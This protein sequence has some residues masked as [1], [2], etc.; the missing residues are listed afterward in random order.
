MSESVRTE[1]L[2]PGP[3]EGLAGLLD[4]DPP[5]ETLPPL[6]HWVYLLDR[7]AQRDLGPDGHPVHGI[8][9]PPAPGLLRMFAGGRIRTH[10]PLRMG[11]AATRTARVVDTVTRQGRSGPLTFVTVRNEI[12]QDG[13]VAVVDEQDLVY[14]AVRSAPPRPPTAEL[15]GPGIRLHADAALLFRFSALTY[16]AHRIHYDRDYCHSEG[17]PGLVVHGPL[18]ALLMAEALRRAGVRFID[19]EF[20][21]RLTAP[22]TGEQTFTTRHA[23][24]PYG[25][26]A[27]VADVTNLTTARATLRSAPNG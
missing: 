17:Y 21:Y 16:N 11:D 24:D 26:T 2:V 4:I 9:E 13:A 14:R 5:G 22:M 3:A 25:W 10:I 18:Q 19:H 6:W 15:T 1:T 23:R 20:R 7:R 12:S 27:E 8:P